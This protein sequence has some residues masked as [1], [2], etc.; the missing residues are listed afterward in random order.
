GDTV[1]GSDTCAA[2]A[3]DCGAAQPDGRTWVF[4]YSSGDLQLL[5]LEG[6]DPG[7]PL[8]TPWEW[9]GDPPIAF[10]CPFCRRWSA[11]Q[12]LGDV[13]DCPA[14]GAQLRISPVSLRADWRPVSAAWRPVVRASRPEPGPWAPPSTVDAQ[15]ES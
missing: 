15:D 3:G 7:P 13:T 10:G 11:V 1:R 9:P 6:V 14:C 5:R 12:V 4:G 2:L 8:V